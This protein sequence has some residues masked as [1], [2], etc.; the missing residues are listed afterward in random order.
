MSFGLGKVTLHEPKNFPKT[1]G[2]FGPIGQKPLKETVV[3]NP[4]AAH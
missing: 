4:R 1:L 2:A 3:I